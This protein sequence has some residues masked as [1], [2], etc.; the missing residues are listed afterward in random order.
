MPPPSLTALLQNAALLLALA[1]V[2]DLATSRRPIGG[3]PLRQALAG[4]ILG[5]IG[6]AIMLAPLGFEPG[7]VFDTRSVL[8]AVSGL[9]LGVIPTVVAMAM[10]AAFR[11][12]QGGAAAWAG[13]SV[14]LA[15]GGI[16]IAWRRW[17]RRPLEDLTWR[18]LYGLGVL[19]HLVMLALM[20]TLPWESARRVIT[21]I[22]PPVLL[23]HPIATAALGAL[24]VN[25]LRRERTRTLLA[26]SESRYRGL[27]EDSHAAM[28]VI[29]PDGGGIVDAN[30]AACRFY[31]WTRT[32]L[33]AMRMTDINA[34]PPDEVQAEMERARASRSDRFLF[35][36]RRADGSLRDVEVFSGPV[37]IQGKQVLYSIV[38]DV[39]DRKRAEGEARLLF[40]EVNASRRVLLSVVEDQKRAEAEVRRLNAELEERV[41]DRTAQLG[42]ANDELEAFSYSV[43]HDLRA[44]LRA[45]N[46][47]ARIL[48]EDHGP[49]LDAE[50]RRVLD[51][52][53]SEALRMGQLI[54]DLLQFSRL[55]RQELRKA[56]T[57]MTALV[58]EV[59][60][61]LRRGVPDRAVEFR[62]G[63]LPEA[64][65]DLAL[66][67]QVWVN[68]LDN[69]LKYTRHRERALITV[70]GS[71]QDGAAVYS[72][73]DN[74]A[75][76]EMKHAGKLFGVFQRLHPAEEF[77][78]T[79]VGLAL[80]QRLVH[81]HGGR[82][83]AQ[84]APDRGATFHFTLPLTPETGAPV[85]PSAGADG[86]P[87]PGTVENG[88]RP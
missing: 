84:A 17:R 55:G 37:A 39:S 32:Q 46:G 14:I 74:G 10:T 42:A 36:H 5:G 69:A 47:Y 25:R 27:F 68:L 61:E 63:S 60:A 52:V 86:L 13:V 59:Q 41:R 64:P 19:V 67:R 45:I 21:R 28:L 48:T 51:V 43:S 30:P 76:F 16:G 33:Q 72:V 2:Y 24:L 88:S 11:L 29:D 22:G 18:E 40:D 82:V 83:W 7:I 58:G 35:R 80:V 81:R 6:I 73:Q 23:V 78:G 38:H 49:R 20:L 71:V 54:D 1:V 70:S 57:D 31:G 87:P 66:V 44:P 8:L 56:P 79:G 53:R 75:G 50:G 4:A 85:V 9:F 65:A 26:E 12:S 34:L 3:R 77:E 15:S 62:L